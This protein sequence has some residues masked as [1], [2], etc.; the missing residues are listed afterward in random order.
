MMRVRIGAGLNG[1]G[2]DGGR[3][4]QPGT[5]DYSTFEGGRM[6]CACPPTDQIAPN[7]ASTPRTRLASIYQG[8]MGDLP[9][10]RARNGHLL[11]GQF[12]VSLVLQSVSILLC[13]THAKT[14]PDG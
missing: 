5:L 12:M 14:R 11:I 9:S 2:A 10:C 1:L 6:E 3:N 8:N 7:T 13:R 4:H